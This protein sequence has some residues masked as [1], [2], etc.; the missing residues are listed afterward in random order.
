M[1]RH[2]LATV[3]V[4]V[5][6]EFNLVLLLQFLDVVFDGDYFWLFDWVWPKPAAVEVEACEVAAVVAQLHSVLVDHGEDE[7][8]E[9]PVEEVHLVGVA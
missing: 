7:D 4:K 8:V 2:L 9:A 5:Q 6:N 3:A 1:T